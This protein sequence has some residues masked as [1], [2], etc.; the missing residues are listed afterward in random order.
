MIQETRP[1]VVIIVASEHNSFLQE[2]IEQ[3][4]REDGCRALLITPGSD[5]KDVACLLQSGAISGALSMSSGS[6]CLPGAIREMMTGKM[7]VDP[8]YLAGFINVVGESTQAGSAT[9]VSARDVA[10][11]DAVRHGFS[12]KEIAA[13]LRSSEAGVKA[14]IRRL[15]RTYGVGSRAQL[16]V[17]TTATSRF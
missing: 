6:A 1:D 12:N 16:V 5:P 2:V 13:H 15:F 3:V 10:V 7:W 11:L 9:C 8:I 4:N 14:A 17:A